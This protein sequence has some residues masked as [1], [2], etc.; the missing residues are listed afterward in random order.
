MDGNELPISACDLHARL[1]FGVAPIVVDARRDVDRF[2]SS[3]PPGPAVHHS[4]DSSIEQ[5]RTDVPDGRQ[6]VTLLLSRRQGK[7][8]RC[9]HAARDKPWRTQTFWKAVSRG[10]PNLDCWP[11]ATSERVGAN[12]S[13]AS[14]RKS[15]ASPAPG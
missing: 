10:E 12:D 1:G 14:I 13:H 5:W 6:V 9:H 15:P 2:N 11:A 3:R 4:P 8:K 7:P